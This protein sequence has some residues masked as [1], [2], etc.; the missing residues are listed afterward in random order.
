VPPENPP[1][2]TTAIA[3]HY[4]AVLR[5]AGLPVERFEPKPGIVSLVST[6]PGRSAHPRFVLNGHLDHFPSEDPALWSFPH[7][8][9]V[10]DGKILGRG[11]SDMRGGLT[12]S[13][14]AYLL[15]AEHRLSLAG[16]LTVMMVGDEETG[17]AW[18]TGHILATRPELAG[19]ACMIG[20][21]ESPAGLRMAEKGRTQ[22]RLIAEMASRTAA[23]ESATMPSS[24]SAR[25]CRRR[26]RS[27]ICPTRP[28]PT[29]CRSWTGCGTTRAASSTTG[30]SG[31]TAGRRCPP[32]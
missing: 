7:D 23:S 29:W 2:D 20:E 31:S 5:R 26:G 10:R 11:V 24:A 15:V 18:G 3:D 16:P 22:F 6:Q 32:A 14:F 9:L 25:R 1:G 30:A 19:D 21:P 27:S 17:G 12:A 8:G 4:T 13:L 28:Q